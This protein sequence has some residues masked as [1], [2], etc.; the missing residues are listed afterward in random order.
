MIRPSGQIS[1]EGRARG[2]GLGESDLPAFFRTPPYRGCSSQT[3]VVM[4][5]TVGAIV[6]GSDEPFLSCGTQGNYVTNE[7]THIIFFDH[8][9]SFQSGIRSQSILSPAACGAEGGCGRWRRR[10]LCWQAARLSPVWPGGEVPAAGAE[11]AVYGHRRSALISITATRR[12]S[13]SAEVVAKILSRM[14]PIR[15]A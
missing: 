6:V 12:G 5:S 13:S 9:K 11:S 3:F 2:D 14:G 7:P 15:A 8:Q 4:G 1:S 10:V